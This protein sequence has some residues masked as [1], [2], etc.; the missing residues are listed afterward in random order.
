MEQQEF[1]QVTVPICHS[2]DPAMRG[3]HVFTGEAS[4]RAEA[5]CLARRG[6]KDARYAYE[7]GLQ[8]PLMWPSG[9]GARGL[10]PGWEPDWSAAKASLWQSFPL[11][12]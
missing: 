9:W 4:S 11:A 2:Q 6:Y 8:I 5:V 10:R 7:A 1:F 3:V 12:P